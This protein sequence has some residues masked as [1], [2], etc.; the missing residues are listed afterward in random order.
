MTRAGS[1]PV[2]LGH[3]DLSPDEMMFWMY[4]PISVPHSYDIAVPHNL[5]AFKPLIHAVTAYDPSAF[6]LRYAYLTAK[7]L[8]V[9]DRYIG[10]RPGWHIDGYGTDDINFIWSDRAPTEFIE[11]DVRLSDDCDVSLR[12]MGSI[13][14]VH[15][16]LKKIVTYPD[17]HLLRLDN[18]V[19]HRSPE[20]FTPGMRTFFKLSLSK[21]RYNLKGNAINHLLPET[22]WPLVDREAVRNH[23][24]TAEADFVK[25]I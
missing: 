14:V 23:P 21:D 13:G 18:T 10:N 7:T 22:H 20:C 19:I 9:G 12:E 16:A 11:T 5:Q 8:W 3:Y 25:D 2:D 17:K 24:A 6:F 4:L 15:R 1:L